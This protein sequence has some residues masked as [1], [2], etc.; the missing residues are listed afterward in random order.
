MLF[1]LFS[2]LFCYH[3]VFRIFVIQHLRKWKT[4]L[5]SIELFK[6]CRKIS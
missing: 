5:K 3:I 1:C 6:D 2:Q 4:R